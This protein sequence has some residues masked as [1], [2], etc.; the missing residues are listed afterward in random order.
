MRHETLEVSVHHGRYVSRVSARR[1]S[2]SAARRS[3]FAPE[4]LLGLTATNIPNRRSRPRF[5]M[6]AKSDECRPVRTGKRDDVGRRV[7]RRS[8]TLVSSFLK[9][10]AWS[11][12]A[13]WSMVR[14]AE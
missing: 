10:G 14:T 3:L 7:E 13:W 2:Y 9:V 4:D 11:F 6:R 5:L 8:T 1:V 12:D